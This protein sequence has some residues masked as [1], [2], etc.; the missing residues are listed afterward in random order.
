VFSKT[1]VIFAHRNIPKSFAYYSIKKGIII[2]SYVY[3]HFIAKSLSYVRGSCLKPSVETFF[4]ILQKEKQFDDNCY[5]VTIV[6][7]RVMLKPLTLDS[8]TVHQKEL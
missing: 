6:E 4:H 7:L 5:T 3:E 1:A 8:E 2:Q